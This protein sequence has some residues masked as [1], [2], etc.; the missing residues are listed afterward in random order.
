MTKFIKKVWTEWLGFS[1]MEN[2]TAL[3]LGWGGAGFIITI[4]LA[5]VSAKV[6]LISSVIVVSVFLLNFISA[7]IITLINK[8]KEKTSKLNEPIVVE[9]KDIPMVEKKEE[10]I[11]DEKV[12][13]TNTNVKKPAA[14]KPV[15]KKPA[16]KKPTKG[17]TNERNKNNKP[18]G[19]KPKPKKKVTKSTTNKK[20]ETH[21]K[22]TTAKKTP[23]KKPNSNSTKTD[24][25]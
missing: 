20:T 25:K 3:A 8:K 16:T 6:S 9:T 2:P 21:K 12:K 7:G 4:A 13:K 10:V 19:S 5:L 11:K 24:K 1:T 22:G 15:S 17:G 23:R 18:S 14:K